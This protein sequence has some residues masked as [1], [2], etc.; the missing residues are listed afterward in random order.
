MP[1][2][3][4]LIILCTDEMRGDCLGANG[5]NADV[6]TP[7]MDRF[8][9]RAVNFTRH[10]TSFPK[11]VPARVSLMTGRYCHT[12]GYRTITQHMPFGTPDVLAT[13]RAQGHQAALFGKNHCW[14][15][16][17]EASH[18][19]PRLKPGQRGL[20]VDHH[21]WTP[22]FA[23][24][25]HRFRD[26]P[27]EDRP[28]PNG[29]TPLELEAGFTYRGCR[30]EASDEAYTEQ[31]IEY[32]TRVRNKDRPFFLQVNLEKPHPPYEVE[33]PYFSMYRRDA[34]APF[35]YGLPRNAPLPLVRQREVRTGVDAPEAAF[36]E[37]QA[38][39]YGMVSKVDHLMGRLLS[40]IESQGLL[41]DSIVMVW[42]DHGD[43]AGQY[44]LPEKWDTT[45]ADC[46][47]HVPFVLHAPGLPRG[48]RVESLTDHTD[49]APTVLELLGMSP[50]PGTHGRSLLP[51]IAGEPGRDA[52]F[53]E[54]GHEDEMLRRF[55]KPQRDPNRRDGKQ[56]VYRLDPDTMA[57]AKMIRTDRYKLVVRLRGGNELYDLT[58]DRWEM[59]NLWGPDGPPA[60]LLPVVHRL[61]T[62]LIEWCLE[63]DPDRP[64]QEVVGA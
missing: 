12:D 33:E 5:L 35:P 46:L 6:R 31:A 8:A 11:C 43:F 20:A 14:E 40:C 17:L 10:F 56:D 27:R 44:G 47:T 37:L 48:R 62:R 21:S 52:V 1:D 19:P 28:D 25:Y 38:V 24:I 42:S 13:L 23:E 57:R 4:N 45:F 36:R 34:I 64:R 29:A 18:E 61:Q 54:G 59:N 39:Y 16:L 53:S 26:Q 15:N 22:R 63:T 55:N 60:S 9:D 49:V 2:A 51:V 3:R 58:E 30:R 50:L 41:E 7:E 32:L